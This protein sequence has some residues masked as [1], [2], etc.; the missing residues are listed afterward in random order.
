[1]LKLFCVQMLIIIS[2]GLDQNDKPP[3]VEQ[4]DISSLEQTITP[5]PTNLMETCGGIDL[6][7]G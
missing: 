2:W 6:D 7:Q 1:M 5:V 3:S 4:I